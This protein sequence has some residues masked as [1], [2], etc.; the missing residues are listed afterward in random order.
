MA[1]FGYD[2][3]NF[4]EVW[5]T[6][7]TMEDLENL[8]K[9]AKKLGTMRWKSF[10]TKLPAAFKRVVVCFSGLKVLLDFVPNHT[11]DEHE[12]FQKSVKRIEPYTDYYVW[13]NPKIV[14]GQR[15]PPNNWVSSV[16]GICVLSTVK[17]KIMS[18]RNTIIPKTWLV[19]LTT[20]SK[21]CRKETC[22]IRIYGKTVE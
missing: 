15:Q 16:F 5:P 3:S 10:F 13:K 11:S 1:D 7:G 17:Y 9:K 14:N 12:W 2:I 20:P 22:S 8:I 19:W 21:A 6:F 4:H 18:R